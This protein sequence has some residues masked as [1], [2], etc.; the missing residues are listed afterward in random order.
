MSS[1]PAPPTPGDQTDFLLAAYEPWGETYLRNEE[2]GD[3]RVNFHITLTTFLLGGVLGGVLGGLTLLAVRGG[4]ER[5]K[6]EATGEVGVG[7]SQ[8]VAEGLQA[9]YGPQLR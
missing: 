1:E 6:I 9:G 3:R 2:T 8:A 7:A 5:A 4:I